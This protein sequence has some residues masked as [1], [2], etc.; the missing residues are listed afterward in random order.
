MLGAVLSR[1]DGVW[2][3]ALTFPPSVRTLDQSSSSS[4]SSPLVSTGLILGEQTDRCFNIDFC[5]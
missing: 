1:S 2:T 3:F 5:L 4:A